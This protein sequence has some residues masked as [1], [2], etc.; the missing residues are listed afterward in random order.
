MNPRQTGFTMVELIVV[1]IIVGIM[2][3]AV[4]PRMSLLGGF[5]ARGYADQIEAYLR[6]AQKSALAGRRTTRLEL[7]NCTTANG[8]C[9]TA[10]L[11]CVASTYN[12]TPSCTTAC[13]TSGCSGD[14]CA[15]TLPGRFASPQSRVG[16]DSAGTVC[17]DSMGRPISGGGMAIVVSDD[18]NTTAR[19][20]NVEAETG[21]VH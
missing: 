19:T 12:A 10:P 4:I 13:P 9:N 1:M 14:W 5:S 15:M 8:N 7:V 20:V 17:F 18:T 6:Y 11:L 3:V 2:A 16:V 21:Y